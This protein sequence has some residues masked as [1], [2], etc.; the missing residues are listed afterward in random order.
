MSG[1]PHG[2]VLGQFLSVVYINDLVENFSSNCKLYGDDTKLMGIANSKSDTDQIQMDLNRA[3]NWSLKWLVKFN[4]LKYM[5][6]H[7]GHDNKM[8][9]YNINGT[10]LRTTALERDLG[11]Y[12]S[13]D[14][15][16]KQHVTLISSKANS[17]LGLIKK[18]FL[19]PDIRTLRILYTTCVRPLLEFAAPVWYQYLFG[20]IDC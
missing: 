9:K 1:V 11:V 15:K 19:N 12:V 7:L 17:I 16:W 3:Y 13:N 5:V 18:S 8:A 6:M 10:V 20:D 4:E 14:L 2:S